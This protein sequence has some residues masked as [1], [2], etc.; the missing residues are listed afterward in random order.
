LE[1]DLKEKES[2]LVPTANLVDQVWGSERPPRPSNEVFPLEENFTGKSTHDKI[3]RL[4]EQV[5]KKKAT[6]TV[7]SQLDE[8]AWLFNL[9]GSD[10]P[11]NP[12][13]CQLLP[14]FVG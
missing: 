12:G 8:I 5:T 11:Y 6:A 1:K 13:M 2:V 7:V 3:A 4:R 9:R 10:I 14:Y